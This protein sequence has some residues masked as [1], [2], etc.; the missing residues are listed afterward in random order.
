MDIR[1]INVI[2]AKM[3]SLDFLQ[4]LDEIDKTGSKKELIFTSLKKDKNSTN[5]SLYPF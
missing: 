5:D 3:S 2:S 1:W 4:K